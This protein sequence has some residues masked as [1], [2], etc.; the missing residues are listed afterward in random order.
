MKLRSLPLPL[1]ALSLATTTL[2]LAQT[3]T[4]PPARFHTDVGFNYVTGDYGLSS[5]TD[6]YVATAGA[7]YEQGP[8]R[9]QLTV[10]YIVL[11][12]PATVVGDGGIP[13]ASTEREEGLGDVTLSGTY[14]FGPVVADTDLDL[15]A[16]VKFPT[17]SDSKGLGTGE[18]DYY[19]EA[20]ARHHFGTFT[21]FA[22]VGYRFLGSNA[23]YPVK[24]GLY[25]S[26]G[27]ALAVNPSTVIGVS[28]SWR[29]RIVDG[30]DDSVE[31]LGFVAYDIS[32]TWR[33]Q[34]YALTGFTD[35]SPDLGVGASISYRF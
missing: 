1:T 3:T 21:P 22:T 23:T 26:L 8:W 10:P 15:T 33:V 2:V 32:P 13:R 17:A 27:A 28:G 31:L 20:S 9:T 7:T 12:G 16:R 25:A 19:V 4:P 11:T 14:L 18:L 30:G 29:E 34:G 6:V 24:D 5:T 35:A